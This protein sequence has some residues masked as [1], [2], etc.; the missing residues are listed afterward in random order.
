MTSSD[1]VIVGAGPAGLKAAVYLGRA[2]IDACVVDEYPVAGGRLLGQRYRQRGHWWVGRKVA[3]ELLDSLSACPSVRL[4]L[5]T[6]VVGLSREDDRWQIRLSG[7]DG[8]IEAKAVIVATGASEV[9]IPVPNWTLPGVMT[10]GGAQVM[11]NVHGVRPGQRGLI[12]GL[13]ALSFAVAQ[14]LAWANVELAGIVLPPFGPPFRWLGSVD[15]QWSRLVHWM[16]LAPIWMRPL[17]PA[18]MRPQWCR[19]IMAAAPRRGLAV[20]GTRLRPNVRALRIVGDDRVQG[21]EL[22]PCQGDAE[23]SGKP[24]VEPVDFVC[25]SGGL[26]PVPDIVKAAGAAVLE[27]PGGLYDVPVSGPLGETT[28][29][30]LFVAGN[31]LGIEGAQVAMAQGQLAA[32]GTVCWLTHSPDRSLEQER[33][34]LAE[35]EEARRK[36]LILFDPAWPEV[37]CRAEQAWRSRGE[38]H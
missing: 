14:E 28:A 27:S 15:E 11:A 12:I 20:A 37:Q 31:V 18:L 7:A 13:G 26:R 23:P 36:T 35:L 3:Q 17:Q 8:N 32:L 33:A 10:V 21:V 34:F 25:L 30:G 38:S 24:W 29:P 4:L 2:G 1:V 16:H 5:H 19:R 9:P 6:S 22:V